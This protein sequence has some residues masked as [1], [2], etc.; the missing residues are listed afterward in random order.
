MS[1]KQHSKK[2]D[3]I[4]FD[5]RKITG[6]FKWAKTN[7]EDLFILLILISHPLKKEDQN[8]F[9]FLPHFLTILFYLKLIYYVKLQILSFIKYIY[10]VKFGISNFKI[11]FELES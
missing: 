9:N 5:Y 1:E 2:E 4:G 11:V 10:F 7:L 3:E 8:F 6:F